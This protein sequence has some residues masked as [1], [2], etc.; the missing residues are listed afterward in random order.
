MPRTCFLPIWV[1]LKLGY[2]IPPTGESEKK[3]YISPSKHHRKLGIS[4]DAPISHGPMTHLIG[5]YILNSIPR[6]HP[7]NVAKLANKNHRK[8]PKTTG[9]VRNRCFGG[10]GWWP[11]SWFIDPINY[12]NYINY[13]FIYHA[14][15]EFSHFFRQLNAN[16]TGA[17]SCT[18]RFICL[19]LCT[20]I[21]PHHQAWHPWALAHSL[22]P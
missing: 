8:L 2:P 17:P 3:T 7:W 5:Q 12:I 11:L 15:I 19:G 16:S 4:H 13:R 20:R 6:H 10:R 21:Y 14:F 18:I 1:W 9:H 22:E